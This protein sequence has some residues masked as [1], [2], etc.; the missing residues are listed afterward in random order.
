MQ[1]L[2]RGI[3]Q[4][5]Y[6]DANL[7]DLRDR[8]HMTRLAVI[9][10]TIALHYDAVA[11]T[12]HIASAVADLQADLTGFRAHVAER[13]PAEISAGIAQKFITADSLSQ[14]LPETHRVALRLAQF[15]E[16]IN[17]TSDF[18]GTISSLDKNYLDLIP[19]SAVVEPAMKDDRDRFAWH[20]ATGWQP[21]LERFPSLFE[22]AGEQIPI[23]P[24]VNEAL[25][26]FA[27]TNAQF[28]ILSAN[29]EPVV[30]GGLKSIPNAVGTEVT[31][32]TAD[33]I[34]ATDKGTYLRAFAAEEPER[35]QVYL[36]DGGSD[37]A[38]LD[39]ADQIGV[40]FALEG[41]S[42]EKELQAKKAEFAEQGKD[43]FYFTYRDF[44]DIK[45][46][47]VQIS[48]AFPQTMAAD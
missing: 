41:G 5:Q 36:G 15:T 13:Y 39:A 3:S 4:S 38:A 20:F 34:A 42:F 45:R 7:G 28:R 29:F 27:D 48:Q 21:I 19:G 43:L 18:D 11:D 40:F 1:M 32:V 2:E 47:M 9:N 16:G 30:I 8:D 37:K 25:A 12:T 10:H 23:R 44:H 22:H 46:T 26:Y 33:S 17:I 31:A 24:G 14:G 6:Q 35:M